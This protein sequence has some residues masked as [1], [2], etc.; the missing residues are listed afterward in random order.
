MLYEVIT[1]RFTLQGTNGQG[2]IVLTQHTSLL[3][4]PTQDR[5]TLATGGFFGRITQEPLCCLVPKNNLRITSYN[6]CYTKLLRTD[7]TVSQLSEMLEDKDFTFVNV[8]IPYAGDIPQTDLS[9]P[10]DEVEAHLSQL[11]ADK[12]APL[13]LYC[14]SGS[15]STQAA[16]TLVV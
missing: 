11:P 7:I 9:I 3:V 16:E 12:D 2:A 15:M 13:V 5:I 4:A 8:H 10:F 14:R 6:V 1:Q